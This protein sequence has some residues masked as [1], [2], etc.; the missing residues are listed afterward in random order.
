MARAGSVGSGA[1][2]ESKY[3]LLRNAFEEW[4]AMRVDEDWPRVRALLEAKIER[5]VD[6]L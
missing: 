5:H 1:N 2:V 4:G 6:P 3:L